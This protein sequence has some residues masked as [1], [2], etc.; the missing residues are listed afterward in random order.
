M[1]SFLGLPRSTSEVY[2][3]QMWALLRMARSVGM[4]SLWRSRAAP[5][6]PQQPRKGVFLP[7]CRWEGCDAHE[8][9]QCFGG[10]ELGGVPDNGDDARRRVR[11]NP[12]DTAQQCRNIMPADSF[13]D[14]RVEVLNA[15]PERRDVLAE[16]ANL[17]R[18][19]MSVVIATR[20]LRAGYEL[21]GELASDPVLSCLTTITRLSPSTDKRY[22]A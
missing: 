17:E 16:V 4:K 9:G 11:S 1:A 19:G 21:F 13:V 5:W 18:M 7:E 8:G 3:A 22:A 2:L 10:I 6:G 12:F 20:A 14:A 15:A